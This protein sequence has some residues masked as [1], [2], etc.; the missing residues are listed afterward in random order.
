MYL[1]TVEFITGVASLG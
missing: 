1:C